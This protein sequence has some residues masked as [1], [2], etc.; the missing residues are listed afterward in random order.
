MP[1]TRPTDGEYVCHGV[2]W[3]TGDP[4][5]L[6]APLPGGPLAYAEVMNQRLGYQV[7]RSGRWCTGR[8]AF[9][10]TVNVE[11]VACPE[12]ATT[13]HNS[14][15]FACASRD[16]F[17]FAHQFH[18]GGH[19]PDTLI[20]YMAQ[21]HW[22]YLATFAGGT[23]KVGTAAEPRGRSRL[24]EQGALFATY[25]ARSPDGRAVRHLEDA[26]TRRLDLAQTVRAAAKLRALADLRN[27]STA[28][29]SH[30]KDVAR[31]AA[32]LADMNIPTVLT[33]WTPPG[34]GDQL[35]IADTERVRYPHD[36]REGEHG[37]TPRSCIGTQVLAV[38]ESDDEAGYL[39]DLGVLKGRR[40]ILGPF[41][42][43]G[44]A[45]QA[46]LF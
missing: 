23:T 28:R 36:L 32:A 29:A 12:R 20:A 1:V 2:T 3:A 30:D 21:P 39:L 7:G 22:L 34:E 38:L 33:E 44:T 25:L 45:V 43:P 24:D 10:D 9:T 37:F 5:L 17:R 35:R 11:A 46:S 27:L 4:R 16:E 8:Y 19:A 14:Q 18:Q 15:C 40:I 26:L 41:S 13:D 31:A 42:S 6:L